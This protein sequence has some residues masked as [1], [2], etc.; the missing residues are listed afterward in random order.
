MIN[1]L[2]QTI[3]LL[4]HIHIFLILSLGERLNY[5]KVELVLGYHIPNKFNDPEGYAHHLHF[6]LYPFRDG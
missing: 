6:M 3:P 4:T 2:K 5:C 1:F